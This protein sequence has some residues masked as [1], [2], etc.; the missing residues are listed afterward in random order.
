MK[1]CVQDIIC[2][3]WPNEFEKN[4]RTKKER[5]RKG[6]SVKQYYKSNW[7]LSREEGTEKPLISLNLF[8]LSGCVF[9]LQTRLEKYRNRSLQLKYLIS[10]RDPCCCKEVLY[11]LNSFLFPR[12]MTSK[13]WC[14]MRIL[15]SLTCE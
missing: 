7:F 11:C 9:Q 3:A 2:C 14:S 1:K 10:Q 12:M 5:E 6:P 4:D 8:A 15:N 13:T